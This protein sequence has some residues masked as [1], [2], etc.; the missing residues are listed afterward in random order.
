MAP[1]LLYAALMLCTVSSEAT[2]PGWSRV[3]GKTQ[4]GHVPF[5]SALIQ[6]I[7]E[8]YWGSSLTVVGLLHTGP[9]LVCEQ[10]LV[11]E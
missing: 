2:V 3:A 11:L 7:L 10:K 8:I 4:I 5:L 1:L 6:S 9:V